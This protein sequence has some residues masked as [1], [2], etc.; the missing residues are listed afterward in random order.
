MSAGWFVVRWLCRFADVDDPG[1]RLSKMNI[2]ATHNQT[3]WDVSRTINVDLFFEWIA[4]L[5][6]SRTVSL[7]ARLVRA[8]LRSKFASPLPRLAVGSAAVDLVPSRRGVTC[9][10]QTT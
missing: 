4:Q 10:C 5:L 3:N 2:S 7:I 6:L 9:L 1:L 8:L